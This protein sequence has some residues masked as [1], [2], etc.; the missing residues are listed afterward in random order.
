MALTESWLKSN[1]QKS[2]DKKLIKT[3]RE[4]LNARLSPKGK[5]TFMV[6][7]YHNNTR[8]EFDIG[9][10]PLMSLKEARDENRRLRKELEQGYDPKVVRLKEKQDIITAS[11]L[12]ELFDDWYDKYCIE[13]KKNHQEIKRSFELHIFPKLGKFPVGEISLKQWL[14]I[15][16]DIAKRKQGIADR[17][18]TNTKQMLKWAVK[19]E[20]IDR[21]V[22]SDINAKEDLQIRKK[23]TVRVFSDE[24]ITLFYRGHS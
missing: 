16:E 5:I 21:N 10:Y 24:E 18:L 17:L 6:R 15:L 19:R 23:A 11:T 12:Q 4:G 20:I 9:S 8:R 13:N 2:R 1:V 22:L 3:D 14:F 7:Y